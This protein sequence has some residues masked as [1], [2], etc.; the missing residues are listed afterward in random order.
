MVNLLG[1]SRKDGHSLRFAN[2]GCGYSLGR[3]NEGCIFHWAC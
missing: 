2:E 1:M 3:V